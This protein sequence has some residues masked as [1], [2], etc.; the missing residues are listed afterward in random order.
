MELIGRCRNSIPN[1]RHQRQREFDPQDADCRINQIISQE[2]ETWT[3]S[4]VLVHSGIGYKGGNWND[5]NPRVLDL[6]PEIYL[7]GRRVCVQLE[8][9]APRCKQK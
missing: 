5:V 3:F 4:Y 2:I 6:P 9:F 8:K 1:E 7:H